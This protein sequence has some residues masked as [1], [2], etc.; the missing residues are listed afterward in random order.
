MLKVVSTSET[1][2]THERNRLLFIFKRN[3]FD[4]TSFHQQLTLLRSMWSVPRADT[5][6][7]TA[8]G[9]LETKVR[10]RLPGNYSIKA[11]AGI[12]SEQFLKV[13]WK[14]TQGVSSPRWTKR[15]RKP[16]RKD[17]IPMGAQILS[18]VMATSL[19]Y[20]LDWLCQPIQCHQILEGYITGKAF[21]FFFFFTKQCTFKFLPIIL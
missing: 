11:K 21:F 17:K 18:I 16:K 13:S 2:L 14:I 8:N 9:Y 15:R 5:R 10:W 1:K 4:S 6:V 20:T 12:Q 19:L 7:Y 3:C